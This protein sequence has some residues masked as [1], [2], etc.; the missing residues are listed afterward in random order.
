MR[1]PFGI[2]LYAPVWIDKEE[3]AICELKVKKSGGISSLNVKSE[4]T[5]E[6]QCW[7]GELDYLETIWI[8]TQ[9]SK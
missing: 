3:V 4:I 5:K 9:K 2:N 7:A 1:E 8:T 6:D